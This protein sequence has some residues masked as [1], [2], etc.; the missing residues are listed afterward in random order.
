[1]TDAI[2]GEFSPEEVSFQAQ[3]NATAFALTALAYLKERGLD[4]D[5]Y[6]AFHG[7]RFAPPWEERRGRPVVEAARH[8]LH[9]DVDGVAGL[10]V[11]GDP[12]R[13]G[14]VFANLLNNSA[15]YTEPGGHIGLTAH[16]EGPELVVCV[17]DNGMGLAADMLEEVFQPFVQVDRSAS[18]AQGGLGIGLS[19]VRSLVEL[20]GGRVRASSAGLGR[21]SRFEVRLPLA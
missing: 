18:R 6:V 20:H 10:L 1:M 13:L 15:K 16:R 17:Q 12:M 4:L 2:E 3:N 9:V 8:S 21:G 7:R 5:E 11:D 14:Q 19:I